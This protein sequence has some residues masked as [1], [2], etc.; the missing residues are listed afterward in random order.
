MDTLVQSLREIESDLPKP[1]I[2]D[3]QMKRELIDR[4]GKSVVR[5]ILKAKATLPERRIAFLF[6]S[7]HP[8]DVLDILNND[9]SGLSEFLKKKNP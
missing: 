6:S 1:R 8:Q 4:I 2:L 3:D 5:D 7:Q 9:F